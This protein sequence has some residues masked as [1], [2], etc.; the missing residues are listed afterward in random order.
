[1]QYRKDRQGNELSVLGFGCMRFPKNGK[2]IDID[3]VEKEILSAYNAGVNYFDTAYIYS[4]SEA[5]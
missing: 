3:E 5:A 2:E 1:M 4:G